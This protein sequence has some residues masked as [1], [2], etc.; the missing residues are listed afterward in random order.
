MQ[1]KRRFFG[2]GFVVARSKKRGTSGRHQRKTCWAETGYVSRRRLKI[3]KGEGRGS[4]S[5]AGEGGVPGG[6]S[7]R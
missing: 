1:K 2:R 6:I 7:L 4:P 3:L 5:G